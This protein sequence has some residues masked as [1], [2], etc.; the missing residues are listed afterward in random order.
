[1][2]DK[3]YTLA[4][5]LTALVMVGLAMAG[6]GEAVHFLSG[7]F[8]RLQGQSAAASERAFAQHALM[9]LPSDLGP[10]RN[11]T[12][13]FSGSPGM[14]S[15]PCDVRDQ[16]SIALNP[17][18]GATTMFVTQGK[19]Q[20]SLAMHNLPKLH[21]TFLSADDGSAWPFWPNGRSQDR[22]GGVVLSSGATSVAYL[23]LSKVQPDV[24]AFDLASGDCR[25]PGG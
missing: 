11:D 22:L 19:H 6:A 15:F 25:K 1:M 3:G 13:S 8:S 16:C 2:D 5:A 20:R 23:R 9:S 21:F 17:T 4:E 12:G 18:Q 7:S 10:F 14:I 24:C